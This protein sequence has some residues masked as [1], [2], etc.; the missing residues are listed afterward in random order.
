MRIVDVSYLNQFNELL[1]YVFQVT[2]KDLEIGGYKQ[3]ELI[4][5]KRPILKDAYVLGWFDQERLVSQLAI[6]PMKVNIHNVMYDMG[7]LT[8]VGTYPEYSNIGLMHDLLTEALSHMRHNGFPFYTL[9][10]FLFTE[11]KDL[12]SFQIKHISI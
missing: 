12:K 7:G 4:R 6:Y 9:I 5:S 8:G 11:N 10:A 3:G 1:R 2:K